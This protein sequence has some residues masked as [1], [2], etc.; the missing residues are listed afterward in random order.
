MLPE[1]LVAARGVDR[2][3]SLFRDDNERSG[4]LAQ[5]SPFLVEMPGDVL[6]PLG[7]ETLHALAS[8]SLK[9]VLADLEALIPVI[10]ALGGRGALI[11]SAQ[12]VE[13]IGRWFP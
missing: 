10:L 8:H 3:V 7:S 6:L 2:I 11:E 12:A 5:L 4:A 1:A 13:D 9:D